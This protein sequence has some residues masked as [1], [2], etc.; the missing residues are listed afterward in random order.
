[1]LSTNAHQSFVYHCKNSIAWY[2]G[3]DGNHKKALRLSGANGEEFTRDSPNQ[4]EIEKD[5]CA[6]IGQFTCVHE[7]IDSISY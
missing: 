3:A 1:M 5:D 7:L 2:D 6:V 4:P